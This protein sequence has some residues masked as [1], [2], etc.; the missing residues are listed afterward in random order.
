M[1]KVTLFLLPYSAIKLQVTWL[2]GLVVRKTLQ[3]I[4]QQPAAF[5]FDNAE[6]LCL[7][8]SV[9]EKVDNGQQNDGTQ[10]RDKHRWNCDGII[11]RADLEN[12]AEEVTGQEGANYRYN[13]VDDQV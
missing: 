1:Y 8:A 10:Q 6:P 4:Y 13:N 12:G 3:K 11:D 7:M 9:G 5:F 2:R